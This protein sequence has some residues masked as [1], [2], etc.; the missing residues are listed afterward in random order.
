MKTKVTVEIICEGCVDSSDL[1]DGIS[2]L[3]DGIGNGEMSS[4]TEVID[5]DECNG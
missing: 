3:L 1:L 5:E 2:E 4:T